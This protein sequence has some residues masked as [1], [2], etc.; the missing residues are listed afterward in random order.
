MGTTIS[1][2]VTSLLL[3][4]SIIE[5]GLLGSSSRYHEPRK[6]SQVLPPVRPWDGQVH[7]QADDLVNGQFKRNVRLALVQSISGIVRECDLEPPWAGISR[8]VV[9]LASVLDPSGRDVKVWNSRVLDTIDIDLLGRLAME[10]QV[11]DWIGC[12]QTCP[13][14]DG[15]DQVL[16]IQVLPAL[17]WPS[18]FLLLL[19]TGICHHLSISRPKNH[20]YTHFS[21]LQSY[22][23]GMHLYAYG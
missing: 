6:K 7:S 11:Q 5:A 8:Q 1:I 14:K 2:K 13:E 9:R 15:N 3:G 17:A 22:T 21:S 20:L 18:Q 4:E 19:Y 10:G 12:G 23:Y 16:R